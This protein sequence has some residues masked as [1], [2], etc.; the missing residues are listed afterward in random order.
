MAHKEILTD[1]IK[2]GVPLIVK[3]QK[4]LVAGEDTVELNGVTHSIVANKADKNDKSALSVADG[5]SQLIFVQTLT[6]KLTAAGKK[7]SA[8]AEEEGLDQIKGLLP[9]AESNTRVIVDPIDGTSNF[10]KKH[11]SNTEE[12]VDGKGWGTMIAIQERQPD[13]SW[14]TVSSAI[15]E[16][17]EKDTPEQLTGRLFIAE[18]GKQTTVTKMDSGAETPLNTQAI[19]TTAKHVIGGFIEKAARAQMDVTMKEMVSK[20]LDLSC[21]AQS[22][23]AVATG[24]AQAYYQEHPNLHDVAAIANIAEQSGAFVAVM[25]V[26]KP[27]KDGRP[28]DKIQDGKDRYPIVVAKNPE[29]GM[30]LTAEYAKAKGYDLAT[31]KFR[32]G[33]FTEV[34]FAELA[35]PRGLD[36]VSATVENLRETK[37]V[38][39][40]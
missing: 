37:Q 18:E 15:Y 7:V 9:E 24:K 21:V 29:L 12:A 19:D 11:R 32:R 22:A 36:T 3:V 25:P 38:A 4:A 40:G 8:V 26:L 20:E 17:S 23:L 28:T 31:T 1:T 6:D 39:K 30:K 13:E 2:A 35:Q 16:S 14:K 5:Q 27:G 10:L 33:D 34:S